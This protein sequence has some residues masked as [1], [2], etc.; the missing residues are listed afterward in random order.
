MNTR[1]NT[2]NWLT[3]LRKHAE[4]KDKRFKIL[5]K[6]YPPFELDPDYFDVVD[7]VEFNKI[8]NNRIPLF[9]GTQCGIFPRPNNIEGFFNGNKIAAILGKSLLSG[10]VAG[11]SIYFISEDDVQIITG[12]SNRIFRFPNTI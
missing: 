9:I 3:H 5:P 6:G 10:H 8:E 7:L 4:F 12:D 1:P 2:Q 11:V